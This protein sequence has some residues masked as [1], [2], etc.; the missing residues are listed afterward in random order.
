MVRVENH[1]YRRR[2]ARLATT[3][4]GAGASAVSA[5]CQVM[6][7]E[8]LGSAAEYMRRQRGRAGVI[9]GRSSGGRYN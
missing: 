3:T 6:R 5:S 7:K 2:W 9:P 1:A 8:R 4:A